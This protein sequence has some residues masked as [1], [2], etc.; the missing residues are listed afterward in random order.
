MDYSKMGGDEAKEII[1]GK[2]VTVVGYQKS[3]VDI[4]DECAQVNG[5]DIKAFLFDFFFKIR[6]S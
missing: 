3:A 6:F 2:R 1:K 4:A 5:T